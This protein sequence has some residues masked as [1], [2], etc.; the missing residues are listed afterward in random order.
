MHEKSK[1]GNKASSEVLPELAATHRNHSRMT[2]YGGHKLGYRS[3]I[4]SARSNT[5]YTEVTRN[6]LYSRNKEGSLAHAYLV[7]M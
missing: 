5:A 7:A 4:S 3:G 6:H 2:S 1:Q